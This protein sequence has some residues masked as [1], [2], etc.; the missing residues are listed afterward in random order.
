MVVLQVSCSQSTSCRQVMVPSG[1]AVGFW[2]RAKVGDLGRDVI[3]EWQ[4]PDTQY[5]INKFRQYFS[6]LNLVNN[7]LP[8]QRAVCNH[9]PDW[10]VWWR[11]SLACRHDNYIH[12]SSQIDCSRTDRCLTLN[13]LPS[14]SLM[15]RLRVSQVTGKQLKPPT[16]RLFQIGTNHPEWPFPI[17]LIGSFIFLPSLYKH[18]N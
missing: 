12:K 2:T 18:F 15:C 1:I 6:D 9:S 17:S 3:F 13:L 8:R 7:F 11:Q 5:G 14:M 10:Y 16:H 4:W